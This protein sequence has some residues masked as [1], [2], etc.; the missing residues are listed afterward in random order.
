LEVRAAFEQSVAAWNTGSL[1]GFMALYAENATFA[2][3]DS[4]LLGRAAIQEFYAPLFQPGATRD[5]LAFDEFNVEVLA[6]E[7]VL[8]RAVYRNTQHGQLVRRGTTT[9][10]FRYIVNRWLII[11]DHSS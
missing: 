4:L 2:L 11:H 5:T 7:V 8:V 3:P 9:L 6:P 10:V 1:N